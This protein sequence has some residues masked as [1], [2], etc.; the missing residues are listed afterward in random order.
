[1]QLI[2]PAQNPD[3][4]FEWEVAYRPQSAGWQNLKQGD[5]F[6]GMPMPQR[7]ENPAICRKT[8]GH[9]KYAER[10]QTCQIVTKQIQ[11]KVWIAVPKIYFYILL[12]AACTFLWIETKLS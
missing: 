9:K 6:T 10:T 2:A 7:L 11:Q 5:K 4:P 3:V 12:L 1:M 8:V